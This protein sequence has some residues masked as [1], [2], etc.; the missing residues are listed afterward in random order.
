LR[1]TAFRTLKTAV[2]APVPSASVTMT[3]AAKRGAP[4]SERTAYLKSRN[5]P[6]TPGFDGSGGEKVGSC[7]QESRDAAA[8]AP[9]VRGRRESGRSSEGRRE[10]TI[11]QL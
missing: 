5:T 10:M 9:P 2:L 4:T 11:R 8:S 6:P 7:R 1:T 3:T